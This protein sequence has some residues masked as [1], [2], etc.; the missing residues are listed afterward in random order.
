METILQ[1]LG[2]VFIIFCYDQYKKWKNKRENSQ[3]PFNIEIKIDWYEFLKREK[4]LDE[5]DIEKHKK[6]WD[7]FW[8]DFHFSFIPKLNLYFVNGKNIKL[9]SGYL[10]LGTGIQNVY[11]DTKDER[12][13]SSKQVPIEIIGSFKKDGRFYIE[14]NG[15]RLCWLSSDIFYNNDYSRISQAKQS[16]LKKYDL[17]FTNFTTQHDTP[18]KNSFAIENRIVK[19]YVDRSKEN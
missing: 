11:E 9:Q 10:E 14:I 3:R 16:E 19:I 18:D 6:K 5:K 15:K 2:I 7:Y 12:F 8:A 1:F 13:L 17:E 4:I